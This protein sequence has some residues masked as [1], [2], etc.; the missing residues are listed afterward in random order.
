[1]A[2]SWDD[3]TRLGVPLDSPLI[4]KFRE[5]ILTR[6]SEL[7]EQE[8]TPNANVMWSGVG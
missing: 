8:P 2:E 6:V 1:M 7:R 4:K 5:E 3:W